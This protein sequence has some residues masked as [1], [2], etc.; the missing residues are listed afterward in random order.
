MLDLILEDDFYVK[1]SLLFSL[2]GK[3]NSIFYLYL[4]FSIKLSPPQLISFHTRVPSII[5]IVLVPSILSSR[6]AQAKPLL[7][8]EILTN[9][10][11]FP[12]NIIHSELIPIPSSH[13]YHP[14]NTKIPLSCTTALQFSIIPPP[15][16]L[17]NSLPLHIKVFL[18]LS[19]LKKK[20]TLTQPNLL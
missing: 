3:M 7:L 20:N 9:L 8:I 15:T 18:S 2:L 6:C 1:F 5:D 13:H 10:I 11:Y 12:S 19:N 14:S 17:W 16:K 4:F